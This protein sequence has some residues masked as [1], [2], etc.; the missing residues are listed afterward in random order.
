[1]KTLSLG[2]CSMLAAACAANPAT[3]VASNNLPFKVQYATGTGTYTSNDVVGTDVHRDSEGN[4]VGSTD[5]VEARQHSFQWSD[6]KYFQGH[7][8]LD[9][10]DYYRLAGDQAAAD[11]VAKVR[12]SAKTKMAIGLPVAIAGIAAMVI[13]GSIQKSNGEGSSLT[14]IGYIGGGIVGTAGMLTWYWGEH[15]MKAKHHL[16]MS[17]A[18]QN[19]DLIEECR[20]NRCHTSRGGRTH[21]QASR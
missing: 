3:G 17:R 1:M 15:D 8:Q 12:E 21:E 9:E 16:P 5:H 11:Q 13:A 7:D 20:E 4:E 18:D 10:H 19:A 2:L 6:W 14:T